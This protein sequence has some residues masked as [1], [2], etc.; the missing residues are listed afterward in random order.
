ME[1][2]QGRMEELEEEKK[3]VSVVDYSAK[4]AAEEAAQPKKKKARP[5]VA[6]VV[7]GSDG[8]RRRLN[9]PHVNYLIKDAEVYADLHLFRKHIPRAQ[10][11][12]VL[13][14]VYALDDQ[15]VIFYDKRFTVQDAVIV[16]DRDGTHLYEATV[17]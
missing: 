3:N 10:L 8:R 1:A 6:P 12:N 11:E 15:V 17:K 9:P 16:T 2:L 4:K 7:T 14:D 13:Y 5:D